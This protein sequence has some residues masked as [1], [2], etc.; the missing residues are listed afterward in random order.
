MNDKIIQADVAALQILR[1][2]DPHLL[3][4]CTPVEGVD[5]RVRA[6]I[7]R[8]F[9]LM[10]RARGVGLA[11][12]QVG[13][14]VRLFVASP[15]FQPDD[16]HVFINPEILSGEGTQ[17]G[18]EG[19]LSFP[20]IACKIRRRKTVTVRAIG[21]DG[22]VFQQTASDLLGRIIQHECDHLDGKLLIHR[23]GTVAKLANR[24]ALKELE[25]AFATA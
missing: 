25:E 9:E 6:L 13:V 3:E 4:V 19:C 1:Y 5:D 11:A 8:M 14:T 20:G 18:D 24:R 21:R 15:T 17:D 22:R 12:P 2:P 10:F 16:R 7:D 23:M